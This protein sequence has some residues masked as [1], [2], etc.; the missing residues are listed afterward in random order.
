M[1]RIKRVATDRHTASLCSFISTYVQEAVS[2]PLHQL[3]AKLDSFPQPWPFPRGDVYHW[4]ALL[5]RFDHILELFNREYALDQGPQQRPF[6]RKL[7]LQGD[8]EDGMP[9][10]SGGAQEAEVDSA[11]HASDGDRE[12]VETILHFSRMLIERCGN[13]SL[14][15]SSSRINDLLQTTSL[16]LLR[17]ALRLS[18]RLAQRFQAAKFKNGVLHHAALGSGLYN[19]NFDHLVKIAQPVSKPPVANSA[20]GA[21]PGKGKE[22]I[23][24]A[25]AYNPSDLVAVA[26]EPRSIVA[27]ADVASVHIIYY[28]QPALAP[29]PS[30]SHQPSEAAPATPTPARRT[31]ALGPARDR[32]SMS[33]RTAT[34]GSADGS[35]L[36]K[37][38]EAEVLASSSAPKTYTVT[39]TKVSGTPAWALVRE[40][41]PK[42]PKDAL[43]EFLHKVRV[44]KA[45]AAPEDFAQQL[46]ETRLLAIAN[47]AYSS[48]ESKFQERIGIAD[49]EEQK[50][51]RLAHQLCDLLQPATR[52]Q[53]P[54]TVDCEVAV[55]LT[56]EALSKCRQKAVEVA[57]A[58]QVTQNH[59][60]LYFELRK[61]IASLHAEEHQDRKLEL[62]DTEWREATFDLTNALQL[63]NLQARHG[64][65]MVS[66]GVMSILIEVLTLR[67][68]RAE[69]L[70]EKTLGFFDSFVHN[71]PTAFQTLANIKGFEILADLMSYE[72]TSSLRSANNNGGL[73]AA[74]KSKVIDYSI[75]FVQQA[76]IRQLFRLLIHMYEY[77]AG[78]ND[79]LLRN[80]IDTPPVLG[81]LRTVLDNATTF[82]SNVWISAVNIVSSFIHNE[83]TSFQVVSEAGLVKSFLQNIVPCELPESDDAEVSLATM[84]T[85][86][87]YDKDG[88][89]QYPTAS[90]ILPVG[91]TMSDIPA[92][93]GAIC[94]NESGMKLFR[95]SK[96]LY[97][98]MDIFLSPTHVQALE[99]DGQTA[100]NIGSHFDE[101]SRHHPQLKE[102]II[103]V[104]IAMVKRVA[105]VCKY[106]QEKKAVGIK[107]YQRT[108]QGISVCGGRGAL[109]D[110]LSGTAQ[111]EASYL[112]A[113]EVKDEDA[114]RNKVVAYAHACFKFL[115]GLFQNY[116]MCGLFCEQGGAI[117][118]LDLA[119]SVGVAHDGPSS[120]PWAR[121]ATVFK[122]MCEQKPYLVLPSLIDRT[123]KALAGVRPL[124]ESENSEGTFTSFTDLSE[125]QSSPF[126]A[127]TD[128][129]TVVRS[130]GITLLLCHVL[131]KAFSPSQHPQRPGQPSQL[132]LHVNLVDVYVDL[133]DGLSRLH[134][135]CTWENLTL[136][137]HLSDMLL[138]QTAPKPASLRR[139]VGNGVADVNGNGHA[140]IVSESRSNAQTNGNS[141]DATASAPAPDN[142]EESLTI[143]NVR[144]IRYLLNHS[145]ICIENFFASLAQAVLPK[146]STQ[147]SHRQQGSTVAQALAEA[148]LWELDCPKTQGA[149]QVTR[150]KA[151][152][153]ALSTCFKTLAKPTTHTENGTAREVFSL[154][155]HKFYLLG[156]F[157]KLNEILA[158]YS[159]VLAKE[160]D[161]PE[162]S[163]LTGAAREILGTVLNFYKDVT[164]AKCIT[165]A[166]QSQA[167][168]A[169]G[170]Q[171]PPVIPAQTVVEVRE[172]IIVSVSKLWHSDALE[173]LGVN[174][175]KTIVDILRTILRAEGEDK[176]VRR[177]EKP[178]RRVQAANVDMQPSGASI[179]DLG[180]GEDA[181]EQLALEALYRC[182]SVAGYASSYYAF[183]T[184][185]DRAP[186]FPPPPSS[187]DT[188]GSSSDPALHRNSSVDM[189]DA[190]QQG[191][192]PSTNSAEQTDAASLSSDIEASDVS[193]LPDDVS[194][195]DLRHMAGAPDRGGLFNQ[196][197]PRSNGAPPSNPSAGVPTKDTNEPLITVDDLDDKRRD[198]R[199]N[200]IDRCLEVLSA[201]TSIT[202]ELAELIQAAVAKS[203]D[204]VNPRADIGRTLVSSL[205][206]LQGDEPSE[207]S[208][209]KI[210]AY[211]HLV[212]LILQDQDFFYSTLDE[213]KEYF[214]ALV[215]WI[216][217][218]PEQNLEDAPWIEMVLLIIERVLAEDE[219]PPEVSW[220][221]PPADDPTKALP[222]VDASE[223]IVEADS[224]VTLF[225]AMMDLLPK[226]GKNSSL[227]LS[228]ARVLVTL[229]RRR[230]LASKMSD[231]HSMSKLFMMIRQLAGVVNEKLQSAFM[232]ILRHMVEDEATLR[233]IMQTEIRAIFET[234]RTSRPMD[235]TTYTRSL[236]HLV[237]RDSALFVDVTKNMVEVSRYDGHPARGQI[238]ALKKE[239]PIATPEQIVRD[240]EPSAQASVEPTDTGDKKSTE[241]K[242]PVADNTD[243]VV[244][245]LLREL[246]NYRDVE[247][248][249]ASPAKEKANETTKDTSGDVD[250]TDAALLPT[251]ELANGTIPQDSSKPEKPVFKPEDNV[252]FI[253]RCFLM[254]CLSELLS[255]YT[256]TKVEFIN[257]SRKAEVQPATPS[258][259][260]SGTLNYLLNVLIPLGTLESRDDIA[261]RKKIQTSQA[262]TAVIVALCARTPERRT[263]R[264]MRGSNAKEDSPELTFVQKFILEHALRSFREA[265][266][267]AELLDQRYSRLLALGE[268]FNRMLT[269]KGERNNHMAQEH[270]NGVSKHIGKLMYEKNYVGAFTSAIAEIDL[271]FPNAKRAV[272][273]ILNP[274]KQLTDL[275][276]Y[277]SQDSDFLSSAPGTSE[278]EEIS[279]ATSVSEDDEQDEREA[280]PDLYR[281]SA[282]GMFET[283]RRTRDE[284][285][286]NDDEDEE[287]YDD[288][289]DDGMDY[290]E[291]AIAEH[292]DVVSDDED[293]EEINVMG[294]DMGDIEGVHGDEGMEIEVVRMDEDEE[295]GTSDDEGDEEDEDDE[296]DSDDDDD[297]SDG[298]Q[299]FADHIDQM[300]EITGDNENASLGD[301]DED[302]GWE[303]DGM[304]DFEFAT[305]GDGGSP[306]GGP[307]DT[308]AR[309]IGGDDPSDTGEQDMLDQDMGEEEYFEDEMP[310]A[311]DDDGEMDGHFSGVQA[312]NL[313]AEEEE[314]I[315]YENDVIYEPELEGQS[316][317]TDAMRDI[318]SRFSTALQNVNEAIEDED[319]EGA[320]QWEF[321]VPPPPAAMALLR[322]HHHHHHRHGGGLDEM[323]ALGMGGS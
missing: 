142:D 6:E 74:Y 290:E 291:E 292:G 181:N 121:I 259:P 154:V 106:L 32:P 81:A 31:S 54:L 122:L 180:L 120:P 306:H 165:E 110:T 76:S 196:L 15:A 192:E 269:S 215:S 299:A 27:K 80:L 132:F 261:H 143:K 189:S 225:D 112:D 65:N 69:R 21:T 150:A 42:L 211:A 219:Q 68:S 16:S 201:Q 39:S 257:F 160:G 311:E 202:F 223:A 221:P 7:L 265:T 100:S 151:T 153:S 56:I 315:D 60:V 93:F 285:D 206:S 45:F 227:A 176:A 92:A 321:N 146:K 198:L 67:T 313:F 209:A 73:P 61:V 96:A 302:G 4:I 220:I 242:A 119:S 148:L 310:P 267:S 241:L 134:A 33:E 12:L 23:T 152:V 46:L 266:S 262:A 10:P 256:K 64:Q 237:L 277:L 236:H 240:G 249:P 301:N 275:G 90:G 126:P 300:D 322:G 323:F 97:R 289:Y 129:T 94:L 307:L 70:F 71:I 247:D 316:V 271:N 13:R 244:Q 167:M 210:S 234:H 133:V 172:V 138:A 84:P 116:G 47:L 139:V 83:P 82:G 308:I 144:T 245:F 20:A 226:V 18:L 170:G 53:T 213:L 246:S 304:H 38:K 159:D 314:A 62:R 95:S 283:S 288:G 200:L 86:M 111:E 1:G 140:A 5:D 252:I 163:P 25:L 125:Q 78:T 128:G 224:R 217:L 19:F 85:G 2:T 108:D 293:D 186:S 166:V 118:L 36:V 204:S 177:S 276:L 222:E 162:D 59:G 147:P 77:N 193:G 89:L 187:S 11:G 127:S 158:H 235:T 103:W 28:E 184:Q 298:S 232:I 319:D 72:V 212:A 194:A 317:I 309:V 205:L 228:V 8:A 40:A 287:M 48:N 203:G 264:E 99:D 250:M 282:L 113:A 278:E 279:S 273:Y 123:Q 44:A 115:E 9:Y 131:S 101:L 30:S 239:A 260:R 195:E 58:L 37:S 171:A 79:R 281:N 14:Y 149:D 320:N 296:E 182:N 230:D 35:T 117:F 238:I 51:F 188:I 272:R 17:S 233:H 280:T 218:T 255:S 91:E 155:L 197:N 199:E 263:S 168:T 175:A 124:I 179:A 141:S 270:G 248:K 98:Y 43:Y 41:S 24:Q 312:T 75:P 157:V 207:E 102:E 164:R 243:G 135:A 284:S 136:Q 253:Y 303:E 66:A 305:A 214:D 104:V 88:E 297:D 229:T 145:P 26:K 294:E 107:L 130:M 52:E 295:E 50:R 258:K 216:Q 137:K 114:N 49:G 268:L 318:I 231:K 3:Q 185:F 274:L 109:A 191:L 286:S 208:G 173:K 55:I 183:R 22:K 29:R 178:T 190:P 156:G 254:Q 87:S 169:Q 161:A 251:P 174:H 57:E 105:E 34:A 63:S